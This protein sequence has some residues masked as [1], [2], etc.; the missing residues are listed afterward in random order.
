MYCIFNLIFNLII[1]LYLYYIY[2]YNHKLHLSIFVPLF[3]LH[4]LYI[5]AQNPAF[6]SKLEELKIENI[7]LS[8]RATKLQERLCQVLIY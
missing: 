7:I 1:F 2:N 8:T 5:P 4:V 6:V 3:R